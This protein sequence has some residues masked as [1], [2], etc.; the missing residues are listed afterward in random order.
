[1]KR[2]TS[3]FT[4][5][6]LLVVVAIIALLIGILLPSLGRARDKAKGVRCQSNL[7]NLY[8]G[9]QLYTQENDGMML[10]ARLSAGSSRD[11]LWCGNTTLGPMFGVRRQN[12]GTS[13][14][15]AYEKINKMLDCPSTD[16]KD[17][18]SGQWD[19]DYTYNRF[20]GYAQ[21]NLANA[22]DPFNDPAAPTAANNKAVKR[23]AI[24]RETLIA[25]DVREATGNND[26][27]FASASPALVPISTNQGASNGIA[28]IPHSKKANMLF[29]DGQ[30]IQ[31]DPNKLLNVMPNKHANWVVDFRA[32][33]D[34]SFP[35]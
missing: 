27:V 7:R 3:A 20:C 4:L 35:F 10:P 24:R 21:G 29:V 12:D 16:H 23:D 31:D 6:E 17:L 19:R 28:G 32:T 22:P 5:I 8:S 1:M 15:N 18:A 14:V 33:K 13:Q 2:R 9:I 34:T 25:L 26:Y 30:I 11:Y